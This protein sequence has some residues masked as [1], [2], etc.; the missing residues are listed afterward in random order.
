[1]FW[2]NL[3]PKLI[4]KKLHTLYIYNTYNM[5]VLDVVV[6]LCTIFQNIC[7]IQRMKKRHA[8]LDQLTFYLLYVR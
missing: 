4:L 8:I 1:M 5:F 6:V 7:N 2:T 3:K